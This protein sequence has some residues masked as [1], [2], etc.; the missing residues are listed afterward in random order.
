MLLVSLVVWILEGHKYNFVPFY[1]DCTFWF[2]CKIF[3]CTFVC[4]GRRFFL[5]FDAC[6]CCLCLF[7]SLILFLCS[8]SSCLF[9]LSVQ[10]LWPFPSLHRLSS[11]P[12]SQLDCNDLKSTGGMM[13]AWIWGDQKKLWRCWWFSPEVS[14]TGDDDVEFA[15][16]NSGASSWW[17][18]ATVFLV[19][20]QAQSA[21]KLSPFL[22]LLSSCSALDWETRKMVWMMVGAFSW[23]RLA[24][25]SWSV[26]RHSCE[27]K[28]SLALLLSSSC[29]ALDSETGDS[30]WLE[31]HVDWWNGSE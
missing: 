17:R 1:F 3:F 18:L 12:W 23:E 4:S 13:P 31:L 22:L 14:F 24:I 29:W 8:V 19:W 26:D 15:T 9:F 2:P 16:C 21:T 27:T 6:F 5:L 25:V 11:F 20:W 10:F 7:Y 28:L 30:V